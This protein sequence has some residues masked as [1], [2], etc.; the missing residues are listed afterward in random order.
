MPSVSTDQH[1]SAL[2]LRAH[3]LD[4]L[5][6]QVLEHELNA[7]H[8]VR[9]RLFLGAPLPYRAGNLRAARRPPA[10]VAQLKDRREFVLHNPIIANA[11]RV[12]RAGYFVAQ[13]SIRR[14]PSSIRSSGVVTLR[15]M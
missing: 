15:R 12:R 6:P 2:R 9:S 10:V 11:K 13:A 5:V 1:S 8:Q 7:R 3:L 4:G 14:R